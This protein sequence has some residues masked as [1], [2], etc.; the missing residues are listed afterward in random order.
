MATR[1][2]RL[3]NIDRE[4]IRTL[5]EAN[6]VDEALRAIIDELGLTLFDLHKAF[7]ENGAIKFGLIESRFVNHCPWKR[8]LGMIGQAMLIEPKQI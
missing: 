7:L 3:R 6:N 8:C 5:Y 4:E 2:I 1:V